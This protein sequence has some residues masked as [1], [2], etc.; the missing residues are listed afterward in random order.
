MVW[1][2]CSTQLFLIQANGG[3]FLDAIIDKAF[4]YT[5][6]VIFMQV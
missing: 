4:Q 3:V 1:K 6:F 2:R 5:G